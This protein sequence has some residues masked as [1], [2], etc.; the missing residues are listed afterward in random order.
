MPGI[1]TGLCLSGSRR[2]RI[3]RRLF[4][5]FCTNILYRGLEP[6]TLYEYERNYTVLPPGFFRT[7]FCQMQYNR[8]IQTQFLF[9]IDNMGSESR[10]PLKTPISG[11]LVPYKGQCDA[12]LWS[13]VFSK[14][15]CSVSAP[16]KLN[17]TNLHI[18]FIQFIQYLLYTIFQSMFQPIST[19]SFFLRNRRFKPAVYGLRIA[20]VLKSFN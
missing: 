13:N 11:S 8:R 20:Q 2:I 19:S 17:K 9:P 10:R 6:Q 3:F 5:L 16:P 15:F 14:V 4:R 1:P 7:I 18:Q 12:I